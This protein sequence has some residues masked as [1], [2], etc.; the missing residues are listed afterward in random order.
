[1]AIKNGKVSSYYYDGNYRVIFFFFFL[2]L[3]LSQSLP[4]CVI[5]YYL[6]P[7]GKLIEGLSQPYKNIN[8]LTRTR[9]FPNPFE[10]IPTL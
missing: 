7:F 8:I 5:D 10:N 1:M 6:L 4:I 3:F 9:N 2:Y